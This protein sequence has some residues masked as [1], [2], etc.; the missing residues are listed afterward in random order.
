M[1]SGRSWGVQ[2]DEAQG[3]HGPHEDQS[4]AAG[5]TE[6]EMQGGEAGQACAQDLDQR[7]ANA[8]RAAAVPAASAQ[9]NVADYRNVL[10]GTDQVAAVGAAR[11]R[12]G[13]IEAR[14]GF[15][16]CVA[17]ERGRLEVPFPFHHHRQAVDDDIQKAADE[18][19]DQRADR[20]EDDG[21]LENVHG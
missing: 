15:F 3:D 11:A 14:R 4:P 16:R 19:P 8:D 13:Q 17:P 18:Q 5:R 12:D 9:Q 2:V 20:H 1:L 21:V 6:A 10:E 7:V